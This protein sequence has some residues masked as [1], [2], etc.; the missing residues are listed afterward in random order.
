MLVVILS[1][2]V[3]FVSSATAADKI[4]V[5]IIDG[6]NNHNWKKMTPPMKATLEA[7]GRFT[8][9]VSTLPSNKGTPEQWAAWKPEFAKYDVVVSNYNDGGKCR[10]PAE[11]R[12]EFEKFMSDGGGFVPVHAADNSSGDWP[13][14]NEMIAVGG[15]GGR[16]VKSGFL[17]RKKDGKWSPD[18]APK[19]KSG[20]HGSGWEYPI[21]TEAPDHPIMKGIPSG[22]KH[23]SEEMYNSLRG[24]CKNVT[25]LASAP[26]RKTRVDEPQVMIIKYGKGTACH[27]TLGHVGSLKPIQC[28]GFQTL[29]A[30]GTEFCATGKVTI[31]IPAEF[32]T[33][34]KVS[35]LPADKVTW[36]KPAKTASKTP[37][38][39][40]ILAGVLAG[41]CMMVAW[42]S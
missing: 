28:V 21:N 41:L 39:A 15:W 6:Q 36:G 26:S 30:R 13:A 22:W 14:Y 20:S 35:I 10:W 42:R 31:P 34:D 12:K 33:A 24:P 32:P 8:V 16:N 23:A 19:G 37:T 9:S 4:K 18:P 25:V 2:T 7:T 27:I 29:L 40:I 17:L 11:R 1:M 5:L 38:T 3:G